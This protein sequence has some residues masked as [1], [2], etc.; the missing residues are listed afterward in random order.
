MDSIRRLRMQRGLTIQKL[1]EM[2]GLSV[3]T[4]W[5]IENGRISPTLRTL[6]KIAAALGVS[7]EAIVYGEGFSGGVS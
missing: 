5:L 2:S 7:V 6:R 1:A 4:I 3:A